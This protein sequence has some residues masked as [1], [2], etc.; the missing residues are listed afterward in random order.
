[1]KNNSKYSLSLYLFRQDLSSKLRTVQIDPS[2]LPKQHPDNFAYVT[3]RITTTKY[4]L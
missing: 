4:T 2:E 1:M 3:N